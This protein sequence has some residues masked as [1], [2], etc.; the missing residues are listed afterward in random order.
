MTCRCRG[1]VLPLSSPFPARERNPVFGNGDGTDRT[2][3]RRAWCSTD[4][5]LG[6]SRGKSV[7]SLGFINRFLS[8]CGPGLFAL[9]LLFLPPGDFFDLALKFRG[10]SRAMGLATR[11]DGDHSPMIRD[12]AS[13]LPLPRGRERGFQVPSPQVRVQPRSWLVQEFRLHGQ[14]SL[15]M[16]PEL[17]LLPHWEF[18]G[19][20]SRSEP[21]RLPPWGLME[22]TRTQDLACSAGLPGLPAHREIQREESRS[23]PALPPPWGLMWQTLALALA[24]SPEPAVSFPLDSRVG[25][26][27]HRRRLVEALQMLSRRFPSPSAEV[28]GADRRWLQPLRAGLYRRLVTWPWFVTVLAILGRG[29]RRQG[30]QL[31]SRGL[32]ARRAD[33]SLVRDRVLLN[34]LLVREWLGLPAGPIRGVAQR[35]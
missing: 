17:V 35:R 2:S 3:F 7:P 5:D 13:H 28:M 15:V 21:T 27:A 16:R 20:G 19:Q 12:W 10:K 18:L 9:Q 32:P 29:Q 14:D 31:I 26:G 4:I 6:R 11:H 1:P 34:R 24:C 8:G 23:E 33:R 22:Q 25:P 30:R